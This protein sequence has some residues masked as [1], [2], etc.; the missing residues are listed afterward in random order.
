MDKQYFQ[1]V[2]GLIKALI[3]LNQHRDGVMYYDN[4]Q[5]FLSDIF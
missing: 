1:Y 3:F 2:M 4:K 5:L